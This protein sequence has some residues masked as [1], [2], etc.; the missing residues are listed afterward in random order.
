MQV[1]RNMSKSQP[2]LPWLIGSGV[3]SLFLL[4]AIVTVAMGETPQV[5]MP[6]LHPSDWILAIGMGIAIPATM[7]MYWALQFLPQPTPRVQEAQEP[8]QHRHIVLNTPHAKP[9]VVLRLTR[10][11]DDLQRELDAL[12]QQR[13]PQAVTLSPEPAV[14]RELTYAA[15]IAL[16]ESQGRLSI[17]DAQKLVREHRGMVGRDYKPLQEVLRLLATLSPTASDAPIHEAKQA[18]HE[19][20][21]RAYSRVNGATGRSQP[22]KGRGR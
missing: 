21:G 8:A 7:L 6:V 17:N 22:R 3:V 14:E 4:I 13:A 10:E 16:I 1:L 5:E 15:V 18:V 2:H 19:V 11:R 20:N 9:E 12:K